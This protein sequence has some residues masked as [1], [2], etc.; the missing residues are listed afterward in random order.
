MNRTFNLLS[1]LLALIAVPVCKGNDSTPVDTKITRGYPVYKF[2]S[3]GSID[4]NRIEGHEEEIRETFGEEYLHHQK[5][6]IA[7]GFDSHN[8]LR[9]VTDSGEEIEIYIRHEDFE[10][11]WSTNPHELFA[12]GKSHYIYIEYEAVQVED[13]VCN[14]AISFKSELVDHEPII[15]K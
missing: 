9:V 15:R 2:I 8:P 4:G 1:L 10:T 13:K 5:L 6:M 3:F 11:L 14:R 7:H 12:H